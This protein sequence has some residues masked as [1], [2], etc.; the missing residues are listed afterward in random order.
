M[1]QNANVSCTAHRSKD[2]LQ[3]TMCYTV[4]GFAKPYRKGNG[5]LFHV[6]HYV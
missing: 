5:L 2:I 1:G 3:K 6:L 4:A